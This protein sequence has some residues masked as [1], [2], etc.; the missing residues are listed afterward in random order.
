MREVRRQAALKQITKLEKT[1]RNIGFLKEEIQF[2]EG[3][4]WSGSP[5]EVE[6]GNLDEV[7]ISV[8]DF[9]HAL[10]H[11]IKREGKDEEGETAEDT[12]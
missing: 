8:V 9:L 6:E 3:F 12:G 2:T 5:R 11:A 7:R 10:Y 1:L 4:T